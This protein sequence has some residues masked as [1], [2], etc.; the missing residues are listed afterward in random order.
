MKREQ[1]IFN[2]IQNKGLRPWL[3]I[4]SID[5]VFSQ[6]FH[7]LKVYTSN[8]HLQY[9]LTFERPID[10]KTK[11]YQRLILNTLKMDFDIIFKT[12]DEDRDESLILYWLDNILNKRLKT[13]L[14]D[15]GTL[16]KQKDFALSYINPKNTSYQID[17]QHK[18]DT[19]IMQLLKLALMQL[20]LEVQEAFKDWVADELIVE[21]FYTQ[22][23][24]E[25]IPEKL[26]IQKIQ[27]LEIEP[28]PVEAQTQKRSRIPPFLFF[29][30]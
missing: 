3:D 19:Y 20:Y 28:E 1:D 26:P 7:S 10:Y 22:L 5:E 11:Y 17:Q 23:L 13:Q 9:Q 27:I 14:R 21:D 16:I 29:L 30:L 25:P 8:H 15:I 6:K 24:L 2:D 12:I 18:A 4:N